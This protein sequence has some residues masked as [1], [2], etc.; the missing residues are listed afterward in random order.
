MH[1]ILIELTWLA[2]S[3]YLSEDPIWIKGVSNK[4]TKTKNIGPICSELVSVK[5]SQ[6]RS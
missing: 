4:N 3:Q 6:S 5:S 2:Y 1:L